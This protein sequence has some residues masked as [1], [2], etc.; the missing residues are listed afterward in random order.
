M[1]K[2]FPLKNIV[3][4]IKQLSLQLFTAQASLCSNEQIMLLYVHY[5]FEEYQEQGHPHQSNFKD[6]AGDEIKED[7]DDLTSIFFSQGK[8]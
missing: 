4:T 3:L 8:A 2:Q 5:F 1:R 6:G 7:R